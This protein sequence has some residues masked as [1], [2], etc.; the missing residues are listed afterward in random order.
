ML[1]SRKQVS[2][3]K[4]AAQG[5]DQLLDERM[6]TGHQSQSEL[7]LLLERNDVLETL[8]PEGLNTTQVGSFELNLVQ[9]TCNGLRVGGA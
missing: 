2:Q 3:H 9:S 8:L 6:H 4:M 1:T 5:S 7:G